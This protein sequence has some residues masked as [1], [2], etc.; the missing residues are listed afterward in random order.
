MPSGLTL[1][2]A[3]SSSW[4]RFVAPATRR[5][6]AR[7][8][9]L[10][11]LSLAQTTSRSRRVQY[12]RDQYALRPAGRSAPGVGASVTRGWRR[13]DAQPGTSTSTRAGTFLHSSRSTAAWATRRAKRAPLFAGAVAGARR[14]AALARRRQLRRRLAL[15]HEPVA[16]PA[17]RVRALRP[18]RRRARQRRCPNPT[19]SARRAVPLLAL[20]SARTATPAHLAPAIVSAYRRDLPRCATMPSPSR[21][22][23][24]RA[25]ARRSAA[26]ASAS[27][28]PGDVATVGALLAW[29]RGAR[30]RLGD[31]SWRPGRAVRVAVNHDLARRG[32]AD[33]RRATK[34]RC[35]R[36]SPGG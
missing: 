17:P 3:A 18:L 29:L 16:R 12:A 9:G 27:T 21:S 26:A 28:L 34:S 19:R 5:H 7:S 20:P 1:R 22:S 14:P 13:V 30:R 2:P 15:R 23:I 35:F 11:R 31:A 10:R 6:R 25:C 33:A 36:R 4:T 8:A 32:H 24:S